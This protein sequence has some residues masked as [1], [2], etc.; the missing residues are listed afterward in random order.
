VKKQRPH[1]PRTPAA[2][3]R[4][5][6]LTSTVLRVDGLTYAY[7]GRA[8]LRGISLEAKE[9]E[10]LA[11]LGPNGSG[12]ST[13]LKILSTLALPASGSVQLDRWDVLKDPYETRRHLGVV[14]QSPALDDNLTVFENLHFQAHLYA[15]PPAEMSE[16]LKESLNVFGLWDRRHERVE[17]LSGGLQ[18]RAELAKGILHKPRLLLLDEPS[19]GLDPAARL[20]FWHFLRRLLRST[21]MAVVLTTHLTDEADRSDRVIIMDKGEIVCD[22]IPS[23]L[24]HAV[25][26]EIIALRSPDLE[27][28]RRGIRRRL[29]ISGTVADGELLLETAGGASIL[30]KLVRAFPKLIEAATLRKPSL[31]DVFLQKTGHRLHTNLEGR[32]E[33]PA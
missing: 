26:G 25:G 6:L 4:L 20:E 17:H 30:S 14:F 22:G 13:L 7:P 27:R 24:K 16:R 10:I 5:A 18:R 19:T 11:I 33:S 1:T 15:L 31:E 29:G 23:E 9:G 3:H 21:K 28:L 2:V 12:K 8:V 32:A